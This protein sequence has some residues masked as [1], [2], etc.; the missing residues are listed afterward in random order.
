MGGGVRKRPSGMYAC[1]DDDDWLF[2]AY[3]SFCLG[4]NVHIM[5]STVGYR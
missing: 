4:Q 2:A 3:D 5:T 1:V